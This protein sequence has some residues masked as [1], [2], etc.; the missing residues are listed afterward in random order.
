MI[1]LSV[2]A[3]NVILGLRNVVRPAVVFELVT[4]RN[5]RVV[6]YSVRKG[7]VAKRFWSMQSIYDRLDD[8]VPIATVKPNR[9]RQQAKFQGTKAVAHRGLS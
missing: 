5:V 1:A 9:H 8:D 7:Q 2:P 6:C 4:G 3:V